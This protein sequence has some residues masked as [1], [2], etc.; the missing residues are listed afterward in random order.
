[1]DRFV[2]ALVY[3]VVKV[4]EPCW[5]VLGNWMC[6]HVGMHVILTFDAGIYVGD[7]K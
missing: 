6:N 5:Y 3:V 2:E 4:A 1:M 7:G